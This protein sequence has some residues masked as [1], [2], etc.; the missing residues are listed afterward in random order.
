MPFIFPSPAAAPPASPGNRAPARSSD[1]DP[2]APGSFG[3]AMARS[4]EAGQ[5]KTAEPAVRTPP[6]KQVRRPAEAEK[7]PEPEI[8]NPMAALL[9]PLESKLPTGA[10]PGASAN[11]PGSFGEAVARSR[12]AGQKKPL[13]QDTANPMAALLI[14]LE[15]KLP[16]GALP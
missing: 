7:S 9:V 13:E 6:S 11:A 8:A 3:E 15:S 14:P 10:L 2:N 5:E 1:Q 16:A 12:E 4:R